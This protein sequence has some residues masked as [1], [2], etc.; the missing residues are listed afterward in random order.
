MEKKKWKKKP[1][2]ERKKS[3]NRKC[4]GWMNHTKWRVGESRRGTNRGKGAKWK[5]R[6]RWKKSRWRSIKVTKHCIGVNWGQLKS[7][8]QYHCSWHAT[9]NFKMLG[10]IEV[11]KMNGGSKWVEDIA[12]QWYCLMFM[13]G[14]VST[15]TRETSTKNHGD[16]RSFTL[17]CT[18][19]K[20]RKGWETWRWLWSRNG[21]W[22]FTKGWT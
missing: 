21:N 10:K 19:T 1:R 17:S 14:K 7:A 11:M 2:K 15:W 16:G 12:W 5:R 20:L 6:N 22:S 4:D 3:M 9:K 18:G 13:I 8:E